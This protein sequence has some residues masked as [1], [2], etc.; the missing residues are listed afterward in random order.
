MQ[1]RSAD[2]KHTC[3]TISSIVSRPCAVARVTITICYTHPIVLAWERTAR[4]DW[5][6][7][8]QENND[9]K[10][11]LLVLHT[12]SPSLHEDTLELAW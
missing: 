12:V 3:F 7:K 6:N 11:V 10:C 2:L 1:S 4:I 5:D 9:Y 8:D